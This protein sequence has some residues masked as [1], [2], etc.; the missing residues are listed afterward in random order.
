M[1]LFVSCD[2]IISAIMQSRNI[3]DICIAC[4]AMQSDQQLCGIYFSV[5]LI[6]EIL[7]HKLVFMA[8]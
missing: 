4:A 6:S 2:R 1:M 8:Q 5:V 7:C 3:A